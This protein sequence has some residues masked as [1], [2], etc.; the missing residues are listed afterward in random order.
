MQI[1]DTHMKGNLKLI[2]FSSSN[3]VKEFSILMIGKCMA[4][5]SVV[6]V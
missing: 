3:C 5:H 1:I 4:I 6:R 2:D